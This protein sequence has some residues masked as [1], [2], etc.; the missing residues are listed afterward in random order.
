MRWPCRDNALDRGQSPITKCYSAGA[1]PATIGRTTSLD[2][3]SI[4]PRLALD[5]PI[6]KTITP[7]SLPRPIWPLLPSSAPSYLVPSLYIYDYYRTG[8]G[9]R[10]GQGEHAIYQG[11]ARQ[12]LWF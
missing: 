10:S 2:S 8:Y 1:S 4:N 12:V 9:G 3:S 6:G 11:R 7:V 5:I